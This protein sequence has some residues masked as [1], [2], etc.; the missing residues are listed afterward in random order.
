WVETKDGKKAVEFAGK[1]YTR[2]TYVEEEKP[3]ISATI[4]QSGRSFYFINEEV[5]FEGKRSIENGIMTITHDGKIESYE[6][7][8]LTIAETMNFYNPEIPTIV[9]LIVI[10]FGL[11]VIA[12]VFRYGQY[13][14]LQVAA[15]R[16]IQKMR[17]ALF[18]KTQTLPISYFDNVP[19]GKIVARI[20]NDT[21]AIRDLYVA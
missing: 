15:N 21:E 17:N 12:G 4:L 16:I 20:T 3:E 18:K 6:A 5:P 8:K 19:A 2:A 9:K 7:R 10:Y 14:L 1:H 11:F 13:V